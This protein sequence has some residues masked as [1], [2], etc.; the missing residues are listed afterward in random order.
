MGH[1][2]G[3]IVEKVDSMHIAAPHIKVLVAA[4]YVIDIRPILA[5]VS[6]EQ[7]LYSCLN[8]CTLRV[9]NIELIVRHIYQNAFPQLIHP[10]YSLN[11][12]VLGQ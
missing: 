2:Q 4:V 6:I 12:G 11:N 8:A 1:G 3:A 7:V 10:P 9:G 5:R